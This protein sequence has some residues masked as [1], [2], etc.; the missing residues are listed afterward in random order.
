MGRLLTFTPRRVFVGHA[1]RT[2]GRVMVGLDWR[3][4]LLPESRLRL[5]GSGHFHV[6]LVGGRLVF[7]RYQ[8]NGVACGLT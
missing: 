7:E 5:P 2:R 6:F 4:E 3:E 8:L 1:S